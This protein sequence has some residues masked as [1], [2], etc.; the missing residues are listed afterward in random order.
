MALPFAASF[1]AGTH[2]WK[3]HG[4]ESITSLR[5]HCQ[6]A[7][8]LATRSWILVCHS[9]RGVATSMTFMVGAGSAGSLWGQVNNESLTLATKS[10]ILVCHSL[11][12]VATSMTFRVG[13]GN[14]G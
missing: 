5:M 1:F 12:G 6:Y 3:Y 14:A 13:A 8:P 2:S 7:L 11:R 9:L 10:G 4:G